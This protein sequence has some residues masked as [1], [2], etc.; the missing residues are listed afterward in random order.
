MP[1]VIDITDD[2]AFVWIARAGVNLDPAVLVTRRSGP[3]EVRDKGLPPVRVVAARNPTG[4]A[5][6]IYDLSQY[7]R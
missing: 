3:A 4:P 5:L 2:L 6:L 7:D 1:R